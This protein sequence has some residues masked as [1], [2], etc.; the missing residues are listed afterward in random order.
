M[1]LQFH[2]RPTEHPSCS[3]DFQINFCPSIST[4]TE[5]Q[6]CPLC[7]YNKEDS[8]HN[9]YHCPVL[10]CERYRIWGSM[11]LKPE[12]LDK[13]RVDSLLSIVANT[14]LGLVF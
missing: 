13:V 8:V 9:S 2:V 5:Q 11:F 4:V 12:D 14:G 10:D 3:T 6:E 7:R 1:G